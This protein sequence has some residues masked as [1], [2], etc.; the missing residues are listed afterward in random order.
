[1]KLLAILEFQSEDFT[2]ANKS[3]IL[4]NLVLQYSKI[5]EKNNKGH[6]KDGE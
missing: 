5:K 1:M 3:T 6:K 2:E 4:S